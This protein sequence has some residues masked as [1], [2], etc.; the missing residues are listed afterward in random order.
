[1]T[2]QQNDHNK[3]NYR[4][5][6]GNITTFKHITNKLQQKTQN[7]WFT[8]YIKMIRKRNLFLNVFSVRSS[9]IKFAQI[10][11]YSTVVHHTTESQ[12]QREVNVGADRTCNSILFSV[13]TIMF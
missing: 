3:V 12:K 4:H 9:S 13:L 8:C 6:R 5:G 7:I 11:K 10:H 2:R 1:M